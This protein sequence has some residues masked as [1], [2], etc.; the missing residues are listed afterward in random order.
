MSEL[1]ESITLREKMILWTSLKLQIL[2]ASWWLSEQVRK[3]L[4]NGLMQH[5]ISLGSQSCARLYQQVSL[6][7]CGRRGGLMASAFDSRLNGLSSNPGL[8][9]CI[10]LAMHFTLT[11]PL[12][13]Q[14]LK[15]VPANL[16]LGETLRWTNI[17]SRSLQK[18][19][20]PRCL[21]LQYRN[22]GCFPWCQTDRSETSGSI[23]EKTLVIDQPCAAMHWYNGA[24]HNSRK[25]RPCLPHDQ[26]RRELK[27][28]S[29]N[30][31]CRAGKA[32]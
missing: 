17:P 21:M 16:M 18:Y 3:K 1:K 8:E 10:T 12:S 14:V 23:R 30:R 24:Q 11:L 32:H 5:A 15:W 29:C 27:N 28:M 7:N 26:T 6:R 19:N 31:V 13:A 22:W 25:E 4:R 20:T 9:H 2:W